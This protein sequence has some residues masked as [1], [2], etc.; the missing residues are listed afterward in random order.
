MAATLEQPS[1]EDKPK[2]ALARRGWHGPSPLAT[3]ATVSDG[4]LQAARGV[5]FVVAL[6][7]AALLQRVAPHARVKGRWG[8]T[9]P[10]GLRGRLAV[11]RVGGTGGSP[12]ARWARGGEFGLLNAAALRVGAA[13]PAALV[14]LDLVSYG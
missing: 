5:A 11:G 3:L 13:I 14:L 10:I 9:G 7:V 8:V 6:L 12:V 1:L 2:S 4:H